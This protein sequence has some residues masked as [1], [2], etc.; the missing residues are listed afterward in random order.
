MNNPYLLVGLRKT[1]VIL[2]EM[3]AKINPERFDEHPDPERFSLREV[4][5]HMADWE[6]IFLERLIG[7][8]NEPNFTIISYDEGEFVISRNYAAQQ[9]DATVERF[10]EERQM[11]I[12]YL[13]GLSAADWNKIGQHPERGKMTVYD[14]ANMLLGHDLYHIEQFALLL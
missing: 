2:R 6:P 9:I 7:T 8:V 1:P 4:I 12:Q 3:V 13:E 11:V 14:Q 10:A 5:C